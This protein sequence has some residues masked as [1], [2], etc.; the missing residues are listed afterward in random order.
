MPA[1][2][3]VA[4]LL[5]LLV[6]WVVYRTLVWSL[7]IPRGLLLTRLRIGFVILSLAFFAALILTSRN[8]SPETAIFYRVSAVWMGTLSLLVWTS[9]VFWCLAG[10]GRIAE[11]TISGFHFPARPLGI[12]WLAASAILSAYGV[13]N[14]THPR[15]TAYQVRIPGLPQAWK[16][17][18][19]VLV[20]DIHYGSMRGAATARE[21]VARINAQ[22]PEIVF[23]GGDYF[24]GTPIDTASVTEPLRGL[25]A[26]LGTWFAEG[27]HE[28]FRGTAAFLDALRTH[29]VHILNNEASD[30]E[31]LQVLGLT[32][33][34][35]NSPAQVT[36]QLARI[37]WDRTRPSVLLKHSPVAGE[38]A[39]AAGI[40]LMLSGHTHYG[41][42]WPY[43][44][45]TRRIYG[46]AVYGA[47]Q[48]GTM[49]GITS[50]GFGAWGP[51]QRVGTRAE[52]VVIEFE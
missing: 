33:R 7:G 41:Q 25:H 8:A 49:Q 10:V 47:Y 27:N 20:S 3:G 19:A 6:H 51:P 36:A 21:M 2:I 35:S 42:M 50:S 15:V 32:Y 17:R 45:L 23:I 28:E 46:D 38:A 29:G 12:A 14:T 24:D 30:I 34:A 13:Y 44:L 18:R 52:I 16:G 1:L 5:V 9:L 4:Q 37:A 26:R 40:S 22:Q 39:A 48:R 11:W 43:T 31:G